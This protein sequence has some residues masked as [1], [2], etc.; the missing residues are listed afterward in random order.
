MPTTCGHCLSGSTGHSLAGTPGARKG[1][2]KTVPPH[3]CH[4]QGSH[5]YHTSAGGMNIID[6]SSRGD[7]KA[8]K[9]TRASIKSRVLPLAVSEPQQAYQ[10]ALHVSCVE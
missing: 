8:W 3:F 1:G 7:P 5:T 6:Q 9:V 2:Y 10:G 4:N